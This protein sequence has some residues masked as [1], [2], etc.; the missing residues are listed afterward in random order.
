MAIITMTTAVTKSGEA[1][2]RCFVRMLYLSPLRHPDV[3]SN[4]TGGT[5]PAP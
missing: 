1:P 2:R 4:R 5:S 3:P